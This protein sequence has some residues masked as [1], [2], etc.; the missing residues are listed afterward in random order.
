VIEVASTLIGVVIGLVLVGIAVLFLL[1]VVFLVDLWFN[2][3]DD[4]QLDKMERTMRE[5]ERRNPPKPPSAF[6]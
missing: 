1:L 3:Y 6:V 5:R 2:I 4:I